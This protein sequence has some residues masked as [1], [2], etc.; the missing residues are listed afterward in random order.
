MLTTTTRQGR[1]TRFSTRSWKPQLKSAS[2]D[3]GTIYSARVRE[4]RRASVRCGGL[5]AAAHRLC[6]RRPERWSPREPVLALHDVTLHVRAGVP[7]CLA[8]ARVL[9]R[10]TLVL[11]RGER[12]VLVGRAGAGK[13]AL[14]HVAAGLRRAD[15]GEVWAATGAALAHDEWAP[16][17]GVAERPAAHV[18]ML[19]WPERWG[20]DAVLAV[21]RLPRG[22][23]PGPTRVLRLANG[24]LHAV[25]QG[26]AHAVA[27]AAAHAVVRVDSPLGAP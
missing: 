4:T 27:H 10:V 25:E 17:R 7:G 5:R 19:R 9:D 22:L 11:R 20:R 24:R 13:S 12:V 21:G 14:L 8:T 15:A 23:A 3:A 2:G 26:S 16:R 1:A 18:E 6:V